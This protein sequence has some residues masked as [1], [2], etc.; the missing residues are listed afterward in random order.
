MANLHNLPLNCFE[1]YVCKHESKELLDFNASQGVEY[2]LRWWYD[3]WKTF[4]VTPSPAE[5][6]LFD[7]LFNNIPQNDNK[8]SMVHGDFSLHN[9]LY[10][11]EAITAVLDWEGSHLGDPAE[12][13]A[14]VRRQVVQHM[15]WS[16]FMDHYHACGGPA[17]DESTFTYYDCLANTRNLVA[18]NKVASRIKQRDT[19]DTKDLYLA[20]EFIPEFMQV[21]MD[22]AALFQPK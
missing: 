3:Y 9:F 16:K 4:D 2:Y 12:D 13:L 6:Y 5:L 15:E 14:Y 21:A 18:T 10:D 17:V 19:N 1:E 7:W 20:L 11:G 8:A 22:N